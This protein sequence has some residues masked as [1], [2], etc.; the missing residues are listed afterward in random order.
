M[1]YEC[2]KNL[3]L[4]IPSTTGD[5]DTKAECYSKET[6]CNKYTC[7]DDDTCT[8]DND[9]GKYESET[10]CNLLCNKDS[11]LLCA[12]IQEYIFDNIG[13]DLDCA[14]SDKQNLNIF[15]LIAIIWIGVLLF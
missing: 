4:C 5:Y 2:D 3:K 10:T 8:K 6:D 7:G 1:K 15:L 13:F 12:N 11:G 14:N 9:D